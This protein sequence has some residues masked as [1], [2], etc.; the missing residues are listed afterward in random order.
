MKLKLLGCCLC[1]FTH[2]LIAAPLTATYQLPPLE[3]A[4]AKSIEAKTLKESQV[5]MKAEQ[6]K[7]NFALIDDYQLYTAQLEQKITQQL[8]TM[9]TA[10]PLHSFTGDSTQALNTFLN[11][12]QP[13]AQVQITAAQ[14]KFDETIVL[15]TGI[16][17]QG[18]PTKIIGN[19]EN[20]VFMGE[21]IE[22]FK[23]KDF[24]I[25][26]SKVGIY[27]KAVKNFTLENLNL[28][29]NQRG[30]LLQGKISAGLISNNRF[31]NNQ[32]GGLA[33]IGEVKEIRVVHNQ[34]TQTQDVSNWHAGFLMTDTPLGEE[35]IG[36]ESD[37]VLG[38]IRN[39]ILKGVES[40]PAYN[41]IQENLFQ[42][43]HAAGLYVDGGVGNVIADNQFIDNDKQG[44][45][46][47]GG[48]LLNIVQHN[49]FTNNG[50]RQH[51]SDASLQQEQVLALGKMTDGTS[52]AKL[53]AIALDNAAY[54]LLLENT[55]Q[56]NSGDGIKLVRTAFRNI[57]IFNIILDNNQ[58]QNSKF[59]F[60][61]INVGYTADT[62]QEEG[63]HDFT[64][65]VENIVAANT[66]Y[67]AHHAGVNLEADVTF[68]DIY[69]NLIYKFRHAPIVDNSKRF[70]SLVDNAFPY[71]APMPAIVKVAPP[72][73]QQ[74]FPLLIK[75]LVMVIIISFLMSAWI[76]I[77]VKRLSPE[78]K[79]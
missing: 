51:Q 52:V 45:C 25:S 54:N 19:A 63:N 8:A 78:N 66:L 20:F 27:L 41:L 40:L 21:N 39:P 61:G 34:F 72:V 16:S 60:S 59:S 44:L 15:K 11:T 67:G 55:I 57:L 68:N 24:E 32:N 12:L 46:L 64:P 3:R 23:L 4:P 33:F 56:H 5:M 28:Q 1:F 69:N 49:R 53:P 10:A 18:S 58:G 22:N 70:N 42:A 29:A 17:L 74:E 77:R 35:W 62:L 43:N 50:S 14:L 31:E 73:E 37:F 2:N 30:A 79:A 47:E 9:P 38:A 26:A 65:S 13:P 36:N 7:L 48:A 71:V 75:L 6:L 76:L